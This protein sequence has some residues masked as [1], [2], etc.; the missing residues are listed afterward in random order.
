MQINPI[1]SPH[2]HLPPLSSTLG[3]STPLLQSSQ[4]QT[5]RD[6]P[7]NPEPS[8][9][10]QVSNPKPAR[11]ALPIPPLEVTMKPFAQAPA[12]SLPPNQPW[13]FPVCSLTVCCVSSPGD[14]E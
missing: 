14:G 8:K 1:L 6:H 2:P 13:F 3:G 10:I 12:V 4:G 11:L 5:A 7:D 9:I